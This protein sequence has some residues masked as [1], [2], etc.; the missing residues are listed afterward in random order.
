MA[1]GIELDD[2]YK[3][4]GIQIGDIGKPGV[5]EKVMNFA[6]TM[7]GVKAQ[8]MYTKTQE[9][10][11]ALD[12]QVRIKYGKTYSEFLEDPDLYNVMKGD[13]YAEI[14]TI[15]VEDALRNVYAKSYGKNP[16]GLLSF[17]A[18]L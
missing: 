13:T 2:V 8:D 16:K 7:Y 18:K 17:G 3:Q 10:M 15:A 9:F 4:L 14:Q 12:K 6:Q 11:Y 1:G 5:G